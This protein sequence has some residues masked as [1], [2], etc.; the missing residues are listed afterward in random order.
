MEAGR[1][2]FQFGIENQVVKIGPRHLLED[3]AQVAHFLDQP[4]GD[5]AAFAVRRVCL[6][7]KKH[8]TV[9][10]GGEG[11]D[12]LFAGYDGRYG[13]PSVRRCARTEQVRPWL[14]LLPACGEPLAA[15][16]LGEARYRAS[17]PAAAEMVGMRGEGFP[18]DGGTLRVL[19]AGA[20][21]PPAAP[22]RRAWRQ[23]CAFPAA[24]C[25]GAAAQALDM[26]WQ[27]GLFCCCSRPTK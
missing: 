8:V 14:R 19:T 24:R 20:V 2:A 17:V 7:A 5:P 12:E 15:N 11:A 10:L 16:A 22:P 23:A 4:V 25:R 3:M 13:W 1:T 27:V 21:A 9:L 6:E 26:R 18:L